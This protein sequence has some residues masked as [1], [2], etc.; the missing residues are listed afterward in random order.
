[1]RTQLEVILSLTD[2][3]QAAI[4][5]GEWQQAHA[6]ETERRAA[7]EKLLEGNA[8]GSEVGLALGALDERNQRLIG[9]VEHHKRRV[10]REATTV[11]TGHA[12]AA[13]YAE[14]VS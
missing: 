6:L 13:A 5:N 9:L 14:A 12:G 8:D 11:K 3:V 2:Q 7:L 4:D 10:L 1:M